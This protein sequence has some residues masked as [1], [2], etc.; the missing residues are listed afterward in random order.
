MAKEHGLVQTILG[1]LVPV[2]QDGHKFILIAAVA[3]AVMF[4]LWEPVGW[5]LVIVALYIAYFFRDPP[6]VTPLR[7]GLV[8]APADGMVSSI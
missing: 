5:V 4:M 7:E 8:I 2:H 1:S 6:R 3:A